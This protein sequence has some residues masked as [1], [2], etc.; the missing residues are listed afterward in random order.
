MLTT[1][2]KDLSSSAT[3]YAIQLQCLSRFGGFEL[4]ES[5]I[6][7]VQNLNP[8]RKSRR[9][10]F[11][12]ES[13]KEM[14]RSR[15]KQL[16]LIWEQL[17]SGHA[18]VKEM[19]QD[20]SN[21][22]MKSEALLKENL[23]LAL[24]ATRTLE[25]SYRNVSLFFTNTTEEKIKNVSFL[26]AAPEQLRDLDNS[27]FLDAIRQEL[28][29]HYD[30]LDLKGNY[31]L[32]LIP[33]YA[34]SNRILEKWA[35]IAYDNKCLLITDF[36]H[37]DTPDDV[38]EMF[39]AACLTGAEACKSNVIMTCNWLIGRGK[40]IQVG[41]KE[42]LLVS[43]SG[44]LAGRIYSTL[45]SQVTAG[46]KYGALLEV[47]GVSFELKKS[48]IATLEKLGLVPMVQEYGR[49]MAFSAKTLF[50]GDNIGLQTYSVVRVFD[51]VTKVLID[52][53]NRRAFENFSANTRKDLQRQIIQFLDSITGP[54]RLIEDF[55]IRRFEQD[56]RQK[57]TIHLDIFLKP[58]FPAR[59][60]MIRMD[61]HKGEDANAWETSYEQTK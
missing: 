11:L 7:G 30:R 44:A 61:G 32:L 25:Q 14:D 38:M 8:E 43:P 10:I 57:D 42:H 33:G 15:L 37:M 34:G 40:A 48:E 41:E 36:S 52:F 53:L 21:A 51:Y 1:E 3:V 20:C 13:S 17:L 22:V 59:N 55:E 19:M 4:L 54:E 23:V 6:E 45:M 47:D 58:Y 35:R 46:K 56:N 5:A 28:S 24:Q 9:Q 39:D 2:T 27:R 18:E 29:Q 60:F 12:T 49:V 26:N 31:S 50:T 16:L